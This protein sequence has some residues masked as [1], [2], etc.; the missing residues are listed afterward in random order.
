[1]ISREYCG[2]SSDWK[3]FV[4]G[5]PFDFLISSAY[6]FRSFAF[7]IA[8]AE[9]VRKLN[10]I[11]RIGREPVSSI[12][13]SYGFEFTSESESSLYFDDEECDDDEDGEDGGAGGE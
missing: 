5:L 13:G 6:N 9:L 3:Y 2:G 7:A 11:G 10:T 12:T 8:G 1:M 4:F